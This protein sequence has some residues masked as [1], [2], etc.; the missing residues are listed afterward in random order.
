MRAI[1]NPQSAIRNGFT[2]IELMVVIALMV[3][4]SVAVLPSFVR[5]LHA[6]QLRDAVRRTMVMAVEARGLAVSR[7]TSVSLSYDEATHGLRLEVTPSE[8]DLEPDPT[9]VLGGDP[10][11]R[12]EA[13]TSDHR[14]LEYPL[15]VEVTI[16]NGRTATDERLW[17]YADGRADEA[18]VR[19]A[20]EGMEPVLLRVN[21]A[22]GRLLVTEAAP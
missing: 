5:F 4:A 6:S 11:P 1:R 21:P 12:G 16:D 7:E 3:M 14:L 20:R 2:L 9:A 22:T 15:D 10:A 18:E 13:K 8:A 17:F 19:F